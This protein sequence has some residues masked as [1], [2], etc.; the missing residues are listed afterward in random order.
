MTQTLAVPKAGEAPLSSKAEQVIEAATQLFMEQGYGATSM[1][2]VAKLA[3]V[4]K[5]TL[6]AHFA[7]K[8]ALFEVI[9]GRACVRHSE[10]L[11]RPGIEQED[12]R[13]T[14]VQIGR[15]FVSFVMTDAA[16][17]IYRV[18]IA[19]AAR[20]PELGRI[21]F[22]SGP[23]LTLGRFAAFLAKAGEQGHLRIADPRRAAEQFIGMLK[24]E[25]HL[26]RLL[27]LTPPPTAAEV[28][29][30]VTSAVDTFLR[31]HRP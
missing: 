3:G 1:D 27:A 28:E 7:S 20:F 17:A 16:L 15:D 30:Q 26:R 31:A 12:L 8:E 19:E 14:L 6:Y 22:E 24:G 18:I 29:A 23:R 13:A 2:A 10:T 4:S 9:I 5:A 11:S 21:F 25:L